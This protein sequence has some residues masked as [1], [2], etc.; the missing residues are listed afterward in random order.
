MRRSAFAARATSAR[1]FAI[2]I[3]TRLFAFRTAAAARASA[4]SASPSTSRNFFPGFLRSLAGPSRRLRQLRYGNPQT[5]PRP[6]LRRALRQRQHPHDF[7]D[8][9]P[10]DG[11]RRPDESDEGRDPQRQLHRAAG[12]IRISRFSSKA[13]D[14]LVAHECILDL[15]PCKSAGVEVEDVAKRLMDYGFHAPTVSWP[16]PGTIMIE[17]TES[18]PKHEL[19]RF[20]DAMIA[21]HGGDRR[22]R[23]RRR[24]SQKQPAQKCAA[25][26]RAGDGRQMGPSLLPRTGRLPGELDARA[27]IL[28]GGGADR[29]RLRRPQS[30]LLLPADAKSWPRK[31]ADG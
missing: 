18:E 5:Q 31:V 22:H 23:H 30:L 7:V 13:R 11:R 6:G 12:S 9:Y 20:C 28:A 1:M 4:R 26:R 15:R 24:G 25:H 19:D 17:P 3:C 8:V 21:I 16:V 2:S 10:H 14:G 29:Q 27:E